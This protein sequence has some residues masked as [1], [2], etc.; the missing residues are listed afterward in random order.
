MYLVEFSLHCGEN[1][2]IGFALKDFFVYF[3]GFS[4][5][6]VCQYRF[7]LKH[8]CCPV[9]LVVLNHANEFITQCVRNL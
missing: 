2:I 6:D 5:F 9:S 1:S 7:V 8:F 3:M 4:D